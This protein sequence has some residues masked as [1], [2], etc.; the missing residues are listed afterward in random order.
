MALAQTGTGINMDDMGGG[1]GAAPAAAPEASGD[2]QTTCPT[3]GTKRSF[4][5]MLNEQPLS[6]HKKRKIKSIKDI[7]SAYHEK[8]STPKTPSSPEG[9]GGV[10]GSGAIS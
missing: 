2:E 1:A 9:G 8:V 6:G 3:C 7:K 10:G 5:N 4:G